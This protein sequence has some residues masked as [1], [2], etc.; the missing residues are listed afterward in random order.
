MRRYGAG[1]AGAWGLVFALTVAALTGCDWEER[2]VV[3]KTSSDVSV[4]VEKSEGGGYSY[5]VRNGSGDRIWVPEWKALV[6]P[7]RVHGGKS[8]VIAF[9][10]VPGNENYYV[11]PAQKVFDVSPGRESEEGHLTSSSGLGREAERFCVGYIPDKEVP[12][13]QPN[14]EM[15]VQDGLGI[16]RYDGFRLQRFACSEP[17]PAAEE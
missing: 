4:E 6:V 16:S 13:G 17:V 7:D 11:T 2:L 12:Q 10:P 1:R 9:E 8:L 3:D 15:S 5:R 14:A